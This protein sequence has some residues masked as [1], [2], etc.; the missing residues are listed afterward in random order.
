M[1]DSQH[2]DKS[3]CDGHEKGYDHSSYRFG[4][5]SNGG[6]QWVWLDEPGNVVRQLS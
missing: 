3:D 1:A 6:R 5:R 2:E 4:F